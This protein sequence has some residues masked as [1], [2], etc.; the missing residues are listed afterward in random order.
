MANDC[1]RCGEADATQPAED[2]LWC[3]ECW[4]YLL[5]QAVRTL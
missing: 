2:P 4:E 1:T 5:A 3:E